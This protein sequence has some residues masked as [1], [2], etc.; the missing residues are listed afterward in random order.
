MKKIVTAI[1]F[2]SV[3]F[4]FGQDNATLKDE[5]KLIKESAEPK[6]GMKS[7]REKIE[8]SFRLPDVAEKTSGTVIVNFIVLEDGSLRNF[9]IIKE[10]PSNLGL[11]NELVRLL[12]KSKKWKPALINGVNVRVYYSMPIS[13]V[14]MPSK[15]VVK[16]VKENDSA[17]KKE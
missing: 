10:T 12:K 11:G 14:I 5:A 6:G 1:L 17:P 8:K 15:K 4:G 3:V 2:L 13:V 7:F 9:Q 16:L